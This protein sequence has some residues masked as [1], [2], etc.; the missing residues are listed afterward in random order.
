MSSSSEMTSRGK[1]QSSEQEVLFVSVSE[2]HTRLSPGALSFPSG[3]T[4]VIV[5]TQSACA[6]TCSRSKEVPS[7]S[8]AADGTITAFLAP[9]PRHEEEDLAFLVWA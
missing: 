4:C 9:D 1:Q 3:W 7:P 5:V 2:L 6:K 8:E